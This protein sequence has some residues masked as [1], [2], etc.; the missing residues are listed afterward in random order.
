MLSERAFGCASEV[1]E[2]AV[3]LHAGTMHGETADPST[4]LRSATAYKAVRDANPEGPPYED[5]IVSN[6]RP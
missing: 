6:A 5:T 1:E 3:G 2:S 4:P